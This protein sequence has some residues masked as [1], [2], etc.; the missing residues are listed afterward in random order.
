MRRPKA[1]K[2][3]ACDGAAMAH[4]R[5]SA[6]SFDN[7]RLYGGIGVVGACCLTDGTC[8]I[9][10]PAD[11][12]A[13]QGVFRGS[14]TTCNGSVCLGACCQPRAACSQTLVTDCSGRFR[15]IGT[16]CN[17]P[18]CPSPF[19]DWDGD[20]DVDMDDFAVLQK[21]LTIGGGTV[22]PE[23]TCF[24]HNGVNGIDAEDVLT[25]IGCATG[26]SIVPES[27]PPECAP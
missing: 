11:C 13:A 17:T 3:D 6:V 19:A 26:P 4:Y 2:E 9:M 22:Q 23:C 20:R 18:C 14:G 15:G 8:S 7:V 10:S 21:C 16:D 24:D 27:V 12:A 1:M 25:F 5:S